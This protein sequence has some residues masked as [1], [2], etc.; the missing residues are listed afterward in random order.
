[1]VA[2]ERRAR[3]VRRP[4]SHDDRVGCRAARGAARERAPLSHDRL[5]LPQLPRTQRGDTLLADPDQASLGGA[6][7]EVTAL[8]ADLRGFTSYSESHEPDEVVAL[9]N[10][11][12]GAVVPHIMEWEGTVISYAGDLVFAVFNA[13]TRQ[14]DHVERAAHTT[15]AIRDAIEELTRDEPGLPR[16]GI[17]INTG[18]ALVGNIGAELRDYTVIGD[19]VNVAARLEAAAAAGEVLLGPETRERLGAAAVVEEAGVL[20]LK[21]KAELVPAWRLVAMH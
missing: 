9:L 8:F 20:D 17:G 2:F 7:V 6:T 19:T 10:R 16:F 11:Y 5:A 4:R 13:P 18:P 21:G 12:Y 3:L 15:L 14:P 1:M